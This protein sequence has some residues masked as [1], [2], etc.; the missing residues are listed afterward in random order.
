MFA[1]HCRRIEFLPLT[2]GTG[3]RQP[4]LCHQLLDWVRIIVVGVKVVATI[5]NTGFE[6]CVSPLL[7]VGTLY[8]LT[9][10]QDTAREALK[11][12]IIFGI[13]YLPQLSNQDAPTQT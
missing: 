7:C 8:P 12:F 11:D 9:F 10:S 6:V 5:D 3:L 13:R 2:H 4:C 1:P